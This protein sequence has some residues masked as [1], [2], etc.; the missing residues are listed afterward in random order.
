MGY[1]ARPGNI[2]PFLVATSPTYCFATGP[3]LSPLRGGEDP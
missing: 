2:P 1:G 3:F